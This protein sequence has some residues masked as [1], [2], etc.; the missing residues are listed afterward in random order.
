MHSEPAK[1]QERYD[2]Y[3][4]LRDDIINLRLKPGTF[5]SIKDICELYQTGRSPAREALLRLE[6]EG[7]IMF[8]P[9]HGT[10]VSRLDLERIDNERFVRKSIEE[11]VMR[12][13][14]AMFSPTVLL[15]LEDS[16]LKQ[17]ECMRRGDVR[18]FFAADEEFHSLFYQEADRGYCR[19]VI[20][21]ECC[22]YKRLRLLTLMV[23][24][25]SIKT[26]IQEHES[27][28][29]AASA[30]DLEKLLYWFEI[31]LNRIKT[32]ERRLLKRFPD[33]FQD[34]PGQDKRENSDLQRDFL[35]SIRSRGL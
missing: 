18:G 12:D 7:L 17:R 22:N 33:L 20:D 16:I 28:V 2:I 25:D 13:F 4:T 5:F 10:M 8:L 9:Q 30:R 15:R 27:I 24:E 29:S 31:H 26:I 3:L 35:I 1:K 14:V 11:N 6:P 21:K 34:E 23:D 19:T 32:Q